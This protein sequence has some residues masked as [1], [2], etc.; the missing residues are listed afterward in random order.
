MSAKKIVIV[1]DEPSLVFTLEDTLEN[2][3]YEVFV[4][5]KGDKA[6]EIVKN[7]NPDLMILDLMLPGM[8][9]YD[10]CKKVRS[11][12]YTFPIIMLTARDQEIDKV[13]GLNIGADD[14]M[15]KPFGVKELLARIQARLRRSDQYSNNTPMN[16]ISLG[17]T[18]IDLQNAEA[19]H[20]E[21]GGVELTTREVELIRYLAAHANEPVSRDALLENVWRYEFSTN[22]RTVD[23]H[24]SKLRSKIEV[25][26]DDPKYLVTLHGVGYML[27]MN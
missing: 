2:E 19:E 8:S 23:V 4:A 11:M 26:A 27:K 1:E 15:T 9:G 5:K 17:D 24:I 22:T 25:H 6:V 10:V 12:N 7:E 18:Y 13:T 21:K 16:E 14:Y 3:G 20:P